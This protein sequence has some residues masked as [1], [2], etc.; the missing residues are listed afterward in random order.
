MVGR[1]EQK[2]LVVHVLAREAE[3]VGEAA[4]VVLAEVDKVD[5]QRVGDLE[6]GDSVPDEAAVGADHDDY[7]R[8]AAQ[9]KLLHHM[10]EHRLRW[11]RT[12]GLVGVRPRGA[13]ALG[14]SSGEVVGSP[15]SSR[16]MYKGFRS[17]AHG[18]WAEAEEQA[19]PKIRSTRFFV[20]KT[21]GGH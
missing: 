5:Q 11:R 1:R 21:W 14:W 18:L 3:R 17:D 7:A 6:G 20:H 2:R 16:A 10:L 9:L 15:C 12:A 19:A 13:C 8:V 4:V